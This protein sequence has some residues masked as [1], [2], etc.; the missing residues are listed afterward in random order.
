MTQQL[1]IR[2]FWKSLEWSYDA[3]EGGE[4]FFKACGMEL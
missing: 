3:G 4:Q 2:S 1:V